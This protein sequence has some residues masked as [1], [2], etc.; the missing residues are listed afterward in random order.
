[1]GRI[2]LLLDSTLVGCSLFQ[3]ANPWHVSKYLFSSSPLP[4]LV[5]N[6]QILDTTAPP[7]PKRKT[8]KKRTHTRPNA[9]NDTSL[10]LAKSKWLGA[11]SRRKTPKNPARPAEVAAT[12]VTEGFFLEDALAGCRARSSFSCENVLFGKRSRRWI[13]KSGVST[14]GVLCVVVFLFCWRGVKGK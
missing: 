1:M 8:L 10:L 6:Q 7:N 9:K 2:M 12:P 4:P 11:N 3:L 5:Q 13:W 14:W